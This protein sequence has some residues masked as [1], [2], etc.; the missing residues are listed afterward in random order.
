[1]A[2]FDFEKKKDI[3]KISQRIRS[4]FQKLSKGIGNAD[5]CV[6]EIL[7]RMCEGKCLHQTID[8]AVI[9]YLRT[10]TGRKGMG[11]YTARQNLERADSF[12]PGDLERVL[13]VDLGRDLADGVDF[14]RMLRAHP[15]QDRVCFKLRYGWGLSEA[16]IGNLFGFSESRASQRLARVQMRL[17]A[18]IQAEKRAGIPSE[19]EGE[20]ARVLRP[21]AE[22]QL[23]GMGEIT[24]ERMETGQSF[25][26]ESFD[27]KSF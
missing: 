5:D 9:D 22:R 14:E 15:W 24:F 25:G 1:M 23:W 7:L 26:V 3:E 19:R 10:I 27:E 4:S 8:Q 6:Q 13:P 21:E 17:S 12:G 2:R 11:S 20:M 16:E 18:R